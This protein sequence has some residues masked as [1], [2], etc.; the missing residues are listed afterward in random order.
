MLLSEYLGLESQLDKYG[1]FDPDLQEDSHFFINLQRLK[2]TTIPEFCRS[3]EKIHDHFRKII[4][5]LVF[6][7]KKIKQMLSTREP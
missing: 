4:K 3:Y 1:V 2:Q 7:E 6:A 5:L